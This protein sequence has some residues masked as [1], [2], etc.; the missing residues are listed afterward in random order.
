[1]IPAEDCVPG[2]LLT[3]ARI[4]WLMVIYSLG[5]TV[6]YLV[7]YLPPFRAATGQSATAELIVISF[8]PL[9]WVFTALF[10]RRTILRQYG[11]P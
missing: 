3:T 11:K 7:Y 6:V 8:G 1:V 5:L 2:K 4:P 10:A 9:L